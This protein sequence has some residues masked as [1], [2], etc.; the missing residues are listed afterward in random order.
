MAGRDRA[1]LRATRRELIKREKSQ[2]DAHRPPRRVVKQAS[3]EWGKQ[4]LIQA[5][6]RAFPE[7][8]TCVQKLDDH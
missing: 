7:S 4:T 2:P 5:Y 3:G 8:A 6:S 1:P